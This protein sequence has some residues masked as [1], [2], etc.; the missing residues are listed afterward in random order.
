MQK[1][2]PVEDASFVLVGAAGSGKGSL[3]GKLLFD[4][5]GVSQR[6]AEKLRKEM[7][8]GGQPDSELYKMIAS[9]LSSESF[10][11]KH[12]ELKDVSVT[13]AT[14]GK[15]NTVRNF[16]RT[17]AMCNEVV[18][19]VSAQQTSSSSNDDWRSQ[20][21]R[22]AVAVRALNKRVALVVVTHMDCVAW[23]TDAFNETCAATMKILADAGIEGFAWT[24]AQHRD[25]PKAF[26]DRVRALLLCNNRQGARLKMPRDV[27]HLVIRHLAASDCPSCPFV[28]FD[29]VP[30][31]KGTE[32]LVSF[33][34]TFRSIAKS[35]SQRLA[36]VRTQ[37]VNKPLVFGE[38]D[39]YKIKGV[40]WVVVGKALTGIVKPGL[41]GLWVRGND[42]DDNG[43]NRIVDANGG[44][45]FSI[46]HW[47]MVKEIGQPLAYVGIN[48]KRGPPG[49]WRS[50]FC[51][52]ASR[53]NVLSFEADIRPLLRDIRIK[54]QFALFVFSMKME[55]RIIKINDSNDASAKC[56][57]GITTSVVLEAVHP[58]H[59]YV[60][61]SIPDLSLFVAYTE[62]EPCLTGKVKKVLQY[63][64]PKTKK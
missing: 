27:L 23:S 3:L 63:V 8:D 1:P 26:R 59:C 49:K 37:L 58:R 18:V 32:N 48:V 40:G 24:P 4:C 36:A 38:T 31:N 5:D 6:A 33:L 7:R 16:H 62:N 45:I 21:R 50:G 25:L 9:R 51:L 55:V 2:Y 64:E 29:V 35:Q 46:E 60:D 28:A 15:H 41:S 52:A 44:Q 30:K 57:K 53:Q 56:T 10:R 20:L 43:A 42:A 22:Q 54:S 19:V 17:L 14:S 47:H 39:H 12:L 34:G 11:I 13:V 61:P